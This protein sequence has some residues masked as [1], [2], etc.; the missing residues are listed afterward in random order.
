MADVF[1][2]KKMYFIAVNIEI[3]YLKVVFQSLK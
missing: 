3:R 2:F 1:G